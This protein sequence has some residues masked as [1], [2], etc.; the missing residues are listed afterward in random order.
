MELKW[1]IFSHSSEA[2]IL[3]WVFLILQEILD[4]LKS[5]PS[6]NREMCHTSCDSDHEKIT[7]KEENDSM[8]RAFQIEKTDN[9]VSDL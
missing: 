1:V 4:F 9:E 6:S 2:V 7:V 5:E 8:L 3:D